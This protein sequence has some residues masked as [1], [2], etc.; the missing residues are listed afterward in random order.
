[1]AL[2][3]HLADRAGHRRAGPDRVVVAGDHVVDPVRI[4]VGVDQ[5]D[6]RDPQ[7]LGLAD[8]DRL[9]LQVDHEHGVGHAL[10]VLDAAEVRAQLLQVGLGG[11][12][13][14]RGQQL[15]LALGL[16]ALQIVKPLDPQRDRL[17]VRQQAAQPAVVDERHVGR[18]GGVA[19][20]VA[21]L[22]LGA[23]EQNRA[24]AARHIGGKSAGLLEQILRLQEVDDVDA[25][26]LSEDEAAHLGV[27]TSRLVAEVHAGLQQLFDSYLSHG[28]CSLFAVF[29]GKTRW[30]ALANLVWRGRARPVPA[31]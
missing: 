17:E 4:A 26:P 7:P 27:P 6:D 1:M 12:P 3:H 8:G 2:G 10:H 20:R 9:G 14:A 15:Q 23:D 25:V 19:D 24:A 5:A 21:G 13:L 16:E 18:L 11:H 28:Y 29:T 22:L 31:G 30:S